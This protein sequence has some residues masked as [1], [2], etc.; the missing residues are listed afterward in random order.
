MDDLK[1]KDSKSGVFSDFERNTVGSSQH[2]MV[3]CRDE[4]TVCK[5][6]RFMGNDPYHSFLLSL[7][8]HLYLLSPV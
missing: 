3:N 2:Q 7:L 1:L 8:L 4:L 6:T 5:G